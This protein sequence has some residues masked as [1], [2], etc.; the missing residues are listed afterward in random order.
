VTETERVRGGGR[1][2]E[3][4]AWALHAPYFFFI[5]NYLQ[6]VTTHTSVPDSIKLFLINQFT[7]RTLAVRGVTVLTRQVMGGTAVK[8]WHKR[9]KTL[10]QKGMRSEENVFGSFM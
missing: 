4:E 8:K 10:Q 2:R 3:R 9:K 6:D 5:K 7:C 1:E